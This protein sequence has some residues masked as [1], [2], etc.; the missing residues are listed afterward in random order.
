[1]LITLSFPSKTSRLN[2]FLR[3]HVGVQTPAMAN[4]SEQKGQAMPNAELPNSTTARLKQN[5]YGV[6]TMLTY[7]IQRPVPNQII[8][9]SNSK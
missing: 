3:L 2:N 9:N 7:I 6:S 8:I 5:G 4:W 1:M